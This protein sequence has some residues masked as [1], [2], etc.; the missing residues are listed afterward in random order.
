VARETISASGLLI[1]DIARNAELGPETQAA[2]D[3]WRIYTELTE[4]RLYDDFRPGW[5][6]MH[7]NLEQVGLLRVGYR[8]LSELCADGQIW[9]CSLI[10]ASLPAQE[11][12]TI[13]QAVLDHFRHKL[14]IKTKYLDE[15][16]QQQLRRLAEQMLNDFWGPTPDVNTL[17]PAEQF[18]LPG[19]SKKENKGFSLNAKSALGKYLRA[20]LSLEISKY[21]EFIQALLSLL[22]QH[23]FLRRLDPL[24][25]HQRFQLDASRL[26]WKLGDGG[27]PPP[28]PIYAKRATGAGYSD[29]ARPVNV[30]FQQFYREAAASLA[31]MEA[32]EHTA[33]VVKANERERRERRFRWE[34]SD[35]TKE[36][37]LGR[38]LP[39]IVCSP[40]A[41]TAK[42]SEA[43]QQ[44]NLLLQLDVESEQS[45]F[46]PYRYLASEGFLPGYNFPALPVW[47]WIRRDDGEYISRARFLALR[48]F[49]PHNIIYHEGAKWE[50]VGFKAPPGGL[51]KR[52][53]ER[54][55][56]QT[57]GSFAR[58]AGRSG[59]L[60]CRHFRDKDGFEMDIVLEHGARALAGIEV[61][62]EASVSAKDFR[63]L[64]K[65]SAG[66]MDVVGRPT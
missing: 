62:E 16:A 11:R 37:E 24:D 5:S 4:Y 45:D 56:C 43:R 8:G 3:V 22:V 6:I 61:K 1:R 9:G 20:R 47:A 54:K 66:S 48:E 55:L 53:M 7:P 38:R 26:L 25:D 50:V 40:T 19:K 13:I 63:S 32:R 57:C 59:G 10:L 35:T 52:R 15:A 21:P 2:R 29:A 12:K 18:V 51:E 46:Y 60:Y 14:A 27:P 64:R 65:L 39:Y 36:Q 42:Q 23:G 28:D 33:Q 44:M 49:G 17:Q 41:A 31:A 30:L 58:G 34:N